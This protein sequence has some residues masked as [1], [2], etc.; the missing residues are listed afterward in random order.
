MSGS[1]AEASVKSDVLLAVRVYFKYNMYIVWIQS[2][3]VSDDTVRIP[4]RVL[5]A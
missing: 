1:R 2:G 5:Q 3:I 4:R